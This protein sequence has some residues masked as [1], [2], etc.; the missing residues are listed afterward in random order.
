[1]KVLSS[2]NI[3]GGIQGPDGNR[4]GDDLEAFARGMYA[5]G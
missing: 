5:F 3:E 4:P 2:N 1:M